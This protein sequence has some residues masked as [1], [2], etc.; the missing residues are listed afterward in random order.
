MDTQFERCT[1]KEASPTVIPNHIRAIRKQRG[2][3]Q[4]DLANK[5]GVSAVAVS[6]WENFL[7]A[8]PDTTKVRLCK[9]LDC[10]ITELFDWEAE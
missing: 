10:S 1:P 6:Y 3:K 5:L 2:I 8:P 7:Q 4:A 9:I